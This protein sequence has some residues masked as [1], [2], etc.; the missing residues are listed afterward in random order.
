[1]IPSILASHY[2]GRRNIQKKGRNMG[3]ALSKIHEEDEV[4][5]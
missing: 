3:M 4:G 2:D 5:K 1:V